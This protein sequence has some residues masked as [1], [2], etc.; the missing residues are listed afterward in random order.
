MSP[1][2]QVPAAIDAEQ[3]SFL[4]VIVDPCPP[5]TGASEHDTWLT[6]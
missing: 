5:N 4:A 6:R 3:S 1:Y 2:S